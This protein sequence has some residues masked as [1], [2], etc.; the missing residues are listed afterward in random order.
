[1]YLFAHEV[2]GVNNEVQ[3]PHVILLS[4]ERPHTICVSDAHLQECSTNHVQKHSSMHHQLLAVL[5]ASAPSW[6]DAFAASSAAPAEVLGPDGA[7]AAT[8]SEGPGAALMLSMRLST[9]LTAVCRSST[10][11]VVICVVDVLRTRMANSTHLRAAVQSKKWLCDLG[12][13]VLHQA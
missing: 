3:D 10:G 12:F 13:D 2:K 7:E 11:N 5:P 4:K 8:G 9:I 1:M 6:T